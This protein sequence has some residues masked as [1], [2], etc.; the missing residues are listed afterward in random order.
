MDLFKQV[1]MQHLEGL[2]NRM[3]VFSG[4][5]GR[6]RI[7]SESYRTRLI[8]MESVQQ[9]TQGKQTFAPGRELTITSTDN[10]S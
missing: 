8:L 10:I 2:S 9:L 7:F 1:P 3:E 5:E 6:F 4:I